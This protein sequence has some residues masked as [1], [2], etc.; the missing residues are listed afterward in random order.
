MTLV[1]TWASRVDDVTGVF[2][3]I[4]SQHVLCVDLNDVTSQST[5]EARF[6]QTILPVAD[7]GW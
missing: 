4:Y 6:G 2:N 3:T 7:A 1:V 5:M